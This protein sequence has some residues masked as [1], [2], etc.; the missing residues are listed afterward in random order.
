MFNLVLTIVM[1][2]LAYKFFFEGRLFLKYPGPRQR[3]E[4]PQK[5]YGDVPPARSDKKDDYIDYEE[6]K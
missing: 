2:Y 4:G 3:E 1:I 6:I 5:S